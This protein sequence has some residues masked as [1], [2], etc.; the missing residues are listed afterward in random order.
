MEDDS[1]VLNF[2]FR[3]P[4]LFTLYE[5]PGAAVRRLLAEFAERFTGSSD[6][7]KDDNRRPTASINFITAHD[8]F[9]LNDLV[10]YVDKTA[11]QII[12]AGLE[13]ILPEAGFI[14]EPRGRAKSVFFTEEG[15]ERSKRL[16]EKLFSAGPSKC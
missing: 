15:L 5:G 7:Y 11:E 1:I 6:L 13:E 10:S 8:G 14:T 2:D 9:T 12:V 16:L 3:H 4:E